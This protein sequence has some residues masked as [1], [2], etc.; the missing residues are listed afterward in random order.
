MFLE[1]TNTILS[2]MEEIGDVHLA[3]EG[4]QVVR[5]LKTI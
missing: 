5:L 1:G 3:T 4:N 2:D